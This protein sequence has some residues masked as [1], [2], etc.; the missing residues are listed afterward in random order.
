M[1]EFWQNLP[2]YF[3]PVFFE[4]GSFAVRWY[5][6]M[7]LLGLGT[8]YLLLLYRFK[9]D[10]PPYSKK[11]ILGAL[12]WIFLGLLIGARLGYFFFYNL[13][14]FF[15]NPLEII[16][17]LALTEE[18][19]SL[20]GFYGMSY[21]GGLL[22]AILAFS[23]YIKI[24]RLSFWKTLDFIVPAVPLGYF[25]GRIGNFINGELYGRITDSWLGMNFWNISD[26]Y[27]SK[28]EC[29]GLDILR[30]PSQLYEAFFEG[31]ILFLILWFL[32][33][34][35]KTPGIISCFYLLGYGT[36]RFFIEFFRQPDEHLGLIAMNLSLGQ[37]LCLGMILMGSFI[38]IIL[39]NKN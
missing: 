3:D 38:A 14:F 39:K 10:N 26:V 32:R 17:P 15:K 29:W 6:I 9:K 24:N 11:K 18:G 31:I 8:V 12:P 7:Y 21:H 5:G 25:W 28:T 20:K 4:V 27:N 34:R 33:N 30:H 1:L 35:I 22:G 13:D 23:L 36:F 19:Y 37:F 16:N 2:N